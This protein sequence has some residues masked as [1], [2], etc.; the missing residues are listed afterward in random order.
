MLLV[1]MFVYL[2]RQMGSQTADI[3]A[4]LEAPEI[5][6]FNQKFLNYEGR[7]VTKDANGNVHYM[8]IQDVVTLVNLA[9]DNNK[10]GKIPTQ[11]AV[12]VDNDDWTK[13]DDDKI[14]KEMLDKSQK[15]YQCGF[16][17]GSQSDVNGVYINAQIKLVE[18][19][20]IK[21]V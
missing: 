17:N 8:T 9:K 3:Y 15:K 11:I 12:F 2:F 7:G 18:K 13:M 10:T 16:N 6:E 14:E 20:Y 4:D 19:V 5:D 21:T 1:S